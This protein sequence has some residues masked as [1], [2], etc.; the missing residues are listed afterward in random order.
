[1]IAASEVYEYAVIRVVPRPDREEF[2]NAGLILFCKKKKF[3]RAEVHFDAEK[4]RSLHRNCDLEIIEANLNSLKRIADGGSDCGPIGKM[5]IAE[6][7]RWLTAI[8]STVIQTSRPHP[9]LTPDPSV[10]L[11]HLFN[12]LVY[13]ND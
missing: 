5:E 1:M 7:F 6:R 3:L 10:T 2:V 12:E 8:R 4:V 13:G 9:G 11:T